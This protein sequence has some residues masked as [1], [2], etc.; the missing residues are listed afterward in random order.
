MLYGSTAQWN[1]HIFVGGI[2]SFQWGDCADTSAYCAIRVVEEAEPH[3]SLATTIENLFWVAAQRHRPGQMT[4]QMGVQLHP[5][6]IQSKQY[7][8]PH[9][10]TKAQQGL[11]VGDFCKCRH[12]TAEQQLPLESSGQSTRLMVSLVPAS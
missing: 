4:G 7:C 3:H 11:L 12:Y 5:S 10:S 6:P 8:L 9:L 2:I 1:L